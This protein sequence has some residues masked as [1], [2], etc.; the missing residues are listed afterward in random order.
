MLRYV[1]SALAIGLIST[2]A[3][4]QVTN[5]GFEDPVVND[6]CCNTVPPDSLTGWTAT[7]NVNVVNGTFSSAN[8][9]LAYEGNQYLDLVGQGGSGS[10]SQDLNLMAGWT[11]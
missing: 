3:S 9:N 4:A 8:G 1:L 10:I 11:Y 6:P 2:A 7:P 5:G